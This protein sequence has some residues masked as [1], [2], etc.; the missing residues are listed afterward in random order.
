MVRTTLK[1]FGSILVIFSNL[2][3]KQSESSRECL[4]FLHRRFTNADGSSF[5]RVF[6][7]NPV[8]SDNDRNENNNDNDDN[9]NNEN[10]NDNDGNDDKV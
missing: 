10:N 3:I 4:Q 9:D 6:K 8:A 1:R 2:K 7:V 5:P